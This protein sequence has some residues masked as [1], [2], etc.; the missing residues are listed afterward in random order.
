MLR[1]RPGNLK[2]SVTG[3]RTSE[4]NL[5]RI[6]QRT[7]IHIEVL[8]LSTE[9][10]IYNF[11]DPPCYVEFREV[12]YICLVFLLFQC[13]NSQKASNLEPLAE[14]EGALL[15]VQVL[16]APHP[17]LLGLLLGILGEHYPAINK[18]LL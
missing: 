12:T 9:P 16:H 6:R 2:L 5:R 14:V 1:I 10:S 8:K 3:Y 18:T 13:R 15:V 17:E 4:K 7:F 11:G